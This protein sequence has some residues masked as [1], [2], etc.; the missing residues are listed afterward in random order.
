M[1]GIFGIVDFCGTAGSVMGKPGLSALLGEMGQALVHRGPDDGG[2]ALFQAPWASVGIGMRRLSIIDVENGRQ[3]MSNQDGSVTVVCNGEIYNYRELRHEL[4]GKGHRFRTQSDTEVLIHLYEEQ[5]WESVARL[6][7]MFAFALWDAPKQVLILA[8]DRLGIKPLFFQYDRRR[9][10]FASEIRALLAAGDEGPEVKHPTL[11]RLLML[12]YIPAPDTVFAGFQKL[13]PGTVL[14]VTQHGNE[15]RQYWRPPVA[16]WNDGDHDEAET[17]QTVVDRLQDAVTSHLVSDVP[18]GAF[19]SGGLDSSAVVALMNRSGIPPFHTFS[20]GFDGPPRFNELSY[21]RQVG[22][23]FQTLHHELV[24]GPADVIACL[25]RIVTHL[26]EPLGDPAIVPTYLLA[27]FA[28]GLVKVVLTGEGADELFGGYA[29]YKLDRLAAWYHWVPP[30]LRASLAQWLRSSPVNRRVAQGA[31]ALSHDSP[32][33]R[34]LDWVGTFTHEELLE[35]AADQGAVVRER[36]ELEHLFEGYFGPAQG[37]HSALADMLRVDLLTWLPDDLLAK[38][39]R[40]TMAASLEARVPYLDHPLVE[41]VV[42]IPA[43]MKIRSGLRKAL[44]KG[45]VAHLVPPEILTRRKMG[46]EMPLAVWMRGPLRE[47]V[48]DQLLSEAPAGLFNQGAVD[49]LLDQHLRGVQDHSRQL[50]S[51]LMVKLWYQAVVQE[52]ARVAC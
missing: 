22:D 48:A 51:V 44:L 24:I 37:K 9:L 38:V 45:A 13:L 28:A 17:R 7:G 8:R 10:T 31:R 41:T 35:V 52:R 20:A 27:K 42:K 47:F 30:S 14:L 23:R 19:L 32:S 2:V 26:D 18:V 34:H 11:L 50:W 46:F 33:R 1:C 29:R 3:P 4:I 36:A 40:M 16:V 5:G 49:K 6:R 21:A 12:Q 25:P 39:D 15:T 43:A